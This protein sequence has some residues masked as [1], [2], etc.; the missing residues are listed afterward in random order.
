MKNQEDLKSLMVLFV[1]IVVVF[2]LFPFAHVDGAK[3]QSGVT[4]TA[5]SGTT[6]PPPAGSCQDANGDGVNDVTGATCKPAS[7]PNTGT[8][9]LQL[10]SGVPINYGQLTPG[11]TSAEQKVTIKNEGTS[12]T[13][14]KVIIK[15]G[16]W[17]SDS[18]VADAPA[19]TAAAGNTI[20]GPEVTRAAIAQVDFN[21]KKPLSLNGWELGQL[22]GGQSIPVYFQLLTW[23]NAPSGSFHQDVTVDLLC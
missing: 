2:Y 23:I 12:Q 6:T 10:V 9:G 7:A 19:G 21:N 11:Q 22:T 17:V 15:G 1:G 4:I 13:P 8:C 18:A 5:P 20:S 16:N 3:F 14:A